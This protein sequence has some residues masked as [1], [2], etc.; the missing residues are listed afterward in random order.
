MKV[1]AKKNNTAI[2]KLSAEIEKIRNKTARISFFVFDTKGVPN[3]ELEYIYE[4]ALVLK[5][6]G[7]NIRMLHTENEFVGVGGWLN[8]ECASLPHYN[9]ASDNVDFSPADFLIIPDACCNIVGYTKELPCKRILLA[10]NLN[11]FFEAFPIAT[12]LNDL[13]IHDAIVATDKIGETLKSL[14]DD[15]RI[16]KIPQMV[17]KIFYENKN[18]L[19]KLF[20]NIIA[21]N[22]SD[23]ETFVKSFYLKYP[24]YKWVSFRPLRNLPRNEFADA[25]KDAAITVWMDSDTDFGTSAI[26]T[27]AS[28]SILVAKVP[29]NE[30]DW[31]FNKD[32][33]KNNAIWFYDV[34]NTSDLL[35]SVV[36]T[37]LHRGIPS[38]LTESM[39]NT[40]IEYSED[41]ITPIINKT[42]NSYFVDR[43][44][45]FTVALSA[46]KNNLENNSKN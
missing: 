10:R 42:F 5:N 19:K 28:G 34:R 40:A 25:L 43:E 36:Q 30:P 13:R 29:E 4:M 41:S 3:G 11:Y 23:I 32:G 20:I 35:A 14:F 6:T 1:K 46:L 45:E 9:V 18:P 37:Y 39:E 44:N 7:Y 15:V 2:D 27:M 26:E 16:T 31:G 8:D 24:A 33:I 21:K 17:K 38:Q 12:T 22:A